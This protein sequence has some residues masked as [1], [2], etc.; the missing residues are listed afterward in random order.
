MYYDTAIGVAA[1]A[2]D[3][4][5]RHLQAYNIKYKLPSYISLM[6]SKE[7]STKPEDV[8]ILSTKDKSDAGEAISELQ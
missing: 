8:D 3:Y 7:V 5:M 4:V 1:N 2:R 6:E